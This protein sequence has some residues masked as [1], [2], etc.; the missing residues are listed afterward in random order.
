MVMS[1][2]LLGE[3]R[4]RVSVHNEQKERLVVEVEHSS[5]EMTFDTAANAQL[6]AGGVALGWA[7]VDVL[8][9]RDPSSKNPRQKRAAERAKA[10]AK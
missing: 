1:H 6:K 5:N 2:A 9:P 7:V 8:K 3:K 4:G 10:A